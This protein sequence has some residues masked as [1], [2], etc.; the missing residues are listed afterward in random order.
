MIKKAVLQVN[1]QGAKKWW[2]GQEKKVLDEIAD[3][4]EIEFE[5]GDNKGEV[6][7][8]TAENIGLENCFS[9]FDIH[10]LHDFAEGAGLDIQT[11]RM[12][13]VIDCLIE[14]KNFVPKPKKKTEKKESKKSKTK[15]KI[16][17]DISTVDL[18]SWFYLK[19]LVDYCKDNDIDHRGSKQVLIKNIRA[20]FDGK[21]TKKRAAPKERKGPA[22][23]KAKTTK[24]AKAAESPKK[25]K[26]VAKKDEKKDDKKEEPEA[27]S[28]EEKTTPK[29]TGKK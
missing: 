4:M 28:K 16:D 20:K 5:K 29:K 2:N 6:I 23:K 19:D 25:K 22:T 7:M 26:P 14:H 1:D 9:H 18:N 13:T 3:R 8:N 11:Q 10:R 27:E 12:E 15:P 21:D 17:K 24:G